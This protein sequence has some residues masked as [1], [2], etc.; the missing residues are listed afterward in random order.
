MKINNILMKLGVII[1]VYTEYE[2]TMKNINLLK[3]NSI[4]IIVVQ[5]EPSNPEKIIDYSLVDYY[6][7]FPDIAGTENVFTDI[8]ERA[9][10]HPLGRNL[11]HAFRSAKSFDVDWWVVILGDVELTG[12]GGIKKIIQ[13]MNS[14]HKTLGITREVGLTFANKYNKP[15]FVEKS[16]THN[17]VPTFFIT[18]MKL[19]KQGIFQDIEIINPF[20]MEE[21]MGVAATK[22]FEEHHYDFFEQSYIIADYA[23]PKFIAGLKYNRDRTILP[24]YIDGVVNA[25]RRFKTKFA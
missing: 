7:K 19:I 15:G 11:S 17:F 6:K 21:C 18:N 13:K 23:Y 3:A 10:S 16:D 20:A 9:I 1:S 25:I 14:N 24:R 5:S 4:P 2:N 8:A 22:F 12:L